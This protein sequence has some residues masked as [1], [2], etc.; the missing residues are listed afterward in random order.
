MGMVSAERFKAVM[1]SIGRL[2]SSCS[3]VCVWMCVS[4]FHTGF[5][6]GGE[7][8]DAVCT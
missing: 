4:G 8:G 7:G 6:A 1:A 5:L 3:C 2:I